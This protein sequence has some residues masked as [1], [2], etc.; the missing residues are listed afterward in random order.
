MD[1]RGLVKEGS[2]GYWEKVRPNKAAMESIARISSML[3]TGLE[4]LLD[5]SFSTD[6]DL[7]TRIDVRGSKF[8]KLCKDCQF[9]SFDQGFTIRSD[10]ETAGQ[11]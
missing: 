7:S 4:R 5:D 2:I 1:F 9:S 6:S 11:P 10:E 8:C 3:D